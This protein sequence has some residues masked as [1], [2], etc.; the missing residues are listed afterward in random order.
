MLPFESSIPTGV[1]A[2]QELLKLGRA[3]IELSARQSGNVLQIYQAADRF[4]DQS[5]QQRQT[6]TLPFDCGY[7]PFG[8]EHSGNPDELDHVDFFACS[9]RMQT[10]A[11]NLPSEPAR[12]LHAAMMRAFDDFE[13]V[14]ETIARL[15]EA[16]ITGGD[17]GERLRGG[18]RRWSRLEVH[19]T[20][21]VEVGA[22]I[23]EPH[24]DGHVL[25]FAHAIAPGLEIEINGDFT[26]VVRSPSSMTVMPGSTL[27]LLTGGEIP[28]LH[29]RVRAHYYDKPRLS[30]LF[31]A[32]LAPSLCMPWRT[33]PINRNVDIGDY[34]RNSYRRFGVNNFEAE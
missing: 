8:R 32:D 22:L 6:A 31:F 5:E 1:L 14:A 11:E 30:L 12:T 10:L 19:R 27:T 20:L 28:P 34:V 21:S 26:P 7:V 16:K 33:N 2:V 24:E 15:I 9:P 29:H 4:F 3:T 13:V 17:L 18:F 23:N 25:T